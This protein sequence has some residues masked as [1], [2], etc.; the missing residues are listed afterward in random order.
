MQQNLRVAREKEHRKCPYLD[1]VDR[2]KLD[3]DLEKVCGIEMVS[4]CR[5][6]PF[7]F[8]TKTSIFVSSAVPTC[9]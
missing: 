7:L 2:E 6:A 1:T 3:F 4:S 5:S 8:L 9:K